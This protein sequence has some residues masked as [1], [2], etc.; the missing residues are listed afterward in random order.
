VR[1]NVL[2]ICIGLGFLAAALYRMGVI[3]FDRKFVI[4][5]LPLIIATIALIV[6]SCRL[7]GQ[8][9]VSDGGFISVKMIFKYAP[10][11][12]VVFIVMGQATAIIDLHR[13][14]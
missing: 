13:Q 6:I 7:G 8:K 2:L 1:L 5:L 14:H 12:T 4:D 11:M 10:M 9:L 3:K